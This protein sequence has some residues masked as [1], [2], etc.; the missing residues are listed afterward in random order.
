MVLLSSYA[1]AMDCSESA[2]DEQVAETREIKTD[3]P[4]HLEGA[5]IIIRL[6]DGRETSVPAEKFKVVP[7]TQQ[8]IITKT[9]QTVA[10]TCTPSKNRM[11]LGAGAGPLGRLSTDRSTAP[12]RVTVENDVGVIAT[13][14]YQRMLGDT[15]SVG[16][17]GQSNS[18]AIIMIG[19]DF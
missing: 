9:T 2:S 5:T 4:K 16:V 7:R 6:A 8:F 3:V 14:Q 15:V 11:S 17:Q 10:K 1:F 13:M 18:S 19:V 12:D